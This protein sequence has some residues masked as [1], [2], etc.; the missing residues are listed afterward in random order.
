MTNVIFKVIPHGSS[1]YITAIQLS[2]GILRRPL[3]LTFSLEELEKEKGYIQ[4]AGLRSDEVIA[5][6]ALVPEGESLKMRR[7]VV[8][9]DLQKQGVGS[10]MLNFCEEYARKSEFKEIYCHARDT[11]IPFT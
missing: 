10:A 9:N 6:A 3:G 1:E 5:T 8:R 4:I 2:E 11:A 7:V